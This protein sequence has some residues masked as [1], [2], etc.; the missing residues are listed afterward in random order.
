MKESFFTL[1]SFSTVASWV[2]R[3]AA[4][5]AVLLSAILAAGC[6]VY[7]DNSY[8]RLGGCY[9]ATDCPIGQRCTSDGYCVAAPLIDGG[10]GRE[11]SVTD[12]PTTD[13][14]T[15]AAPN[16]DGATLVF[17]ANPND[18]AANE[19]CANDGTCRPGDCSTSGCVN[20]F[21][22]AVV[23]SGPMGMACVHADAQ[24]CGADH[25]CARSARCVDGK[26]TPLADLCTDR[27]QCPAGSAC[28]D[29]K[30]V[31]TCTADSQCPSGSLC[32]LALEICDAKAKAC[33]VTGD[34]ASKD[35][36]CVDGGCVPRCGAVG[37]CTDSG[38]SACVDNGCIASQKKRSVCQADGG[39]AGCAKTPGSECDPTIDKWC[40]VGKT[41]IDGVCR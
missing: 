25:Q 3:S 19:T 34:C 6:P 12:A 17:C 8:G 39:A 27:A 37:A 38:A 41:C 23:T 28:V 10:G 21:Q 16:A 24:A 1:A 31:A 26:C 36:V 40:A 2:K 32:R 14:A 13:I 7:S 11:A 20:Q 4:L 15:D 29:G 30:C 18:C 35:L 9:Y 22:C 5:G 33:S